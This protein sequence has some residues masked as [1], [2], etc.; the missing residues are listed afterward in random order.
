MRVVIALLLFLSCGQLLAAEALDAFPPLQPLVQPLSPD[1]TLGTPDLSVAT[2]TVAYSFSREDFNNPVVEIN[3]SLGAMVLELFPDEAP[4]AVANFLGLAD[5]TKAWVDPFTG[6]EVLRPFYDGLVFHRVIDGFMIQGGSP[7]GRGDGSPGFTFRDEINARSL[8][9]D[10]MLLLDDT[11]TPHPLL[12]IGT[13]Q[14]FQQKVLIPLYQEMGIDSQEALANR[15]DEVDR[16]LHTMTVK[17]IYELLGYQYTERFISR[18]PQ[19][20]VIAMANSGPNSNGSQFFITLVDT[21]WLTGKHTVFGKVRVG[22]EV[23]DAIGKVPVDADNRPLEDVFILSV[24][25]L[26]L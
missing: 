11:G 7:N 21:D 13:Q 15:V 18:R 6:A 25:R 23:L 14:A 2:P 3:T 17:D 19:R 9:L 10:K 20:G 8:G 22:L 1:I 26:E 4:Q 16:R 5:G 12:G 24:R